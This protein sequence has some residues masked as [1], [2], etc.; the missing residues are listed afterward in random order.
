MRTDGSDGIFVLNLTDRAP[1]GW[2]RRVLAGLRAV[3]A[4]LVLTAEPATLRA[5]RLGNLVVVAASGPVPLDALR[6]RSSSAAAPYRVL[7]AAQVSDGFGGG[8][9][10]TASDSE[11]SPPPDDR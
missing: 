10:F 1:F 6:R 4:D 3:F 5:R 9:P 11:P 8:T 2:S 7:D